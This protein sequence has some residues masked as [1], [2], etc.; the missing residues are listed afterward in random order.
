MKSEAR[1]KILLVDDDP[2]KLLSIAVVLEDLETDIVR[3]TSGNEA[4]RRLLSEDYAVILLDVNMPVMDGFETA[5]LIRQRKR[6]AHTPIIFLTSFPDDTHAARGYSLG[7]VDYVLTPVLPEVLRAKVSVFVRLHQ[8]TLQAVQQVEQRSALEREQ[9]LRIAAERAN[10]AKNEFLANVSHELRTPM[11]AIMGMTTLSLEESIPRQVREYLETVDSS[12]RIL[13]ALLNELLD[14]SKLT[15]GKFQF[16]ETSFSLRKNLTRLLDAL[17]IPAQEKGLSLIYR[18]DEDLPDQFWGDPIRLSQ[19]LMNL[20]SNAIKF[21]DQGQVELR[22]TQNYPVGDPLEVRFAVA[23]TGIGISPAD[24]EFIFA[25]FTQADTSLTRAQGGTGLGLAITADLVKAMK[26]RREVHS[27]PG[28]GSTFI[29]ILPLRS[30][31]RSLTQL[32]DPPTLATAAGESAKSIGRSKLRVLVAEDVRANQM[33][34]DHALKKRGHDVQ[35]V[36]NGRQAVDYI[37][38]HDVDVILMDLQMPLMDGFQATT[39]IRALPQKSRIPII[40]VTAHA[41][42]EDQAKCLAAGMHGYLSK[43]L[44]LAILIKVVEAWGAQEQL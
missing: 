32:S 28:K 26:G 30:D 42:E 21:T 6:S 38:Q 22:V 15:A 12:A 8:L 43:P 14:F 13:L 19:I 9:S 34:M 7:A 25:P 44:D 4:L 3:V 40:A 31:T 27:I 18:V 24:Q 23:D 17:R 1:V 10:Q 41:T 29:V 37:V 35:I 11:N 16:Q 36:A 33:L 5:A 2:G 20:L 39:A